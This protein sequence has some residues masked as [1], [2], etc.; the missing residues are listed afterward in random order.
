MWTSPLI[1][2]HALTPNNSY[3]ELHPF[4]SDACS[5]HSVARH[6]SV[7][8]YLHVHFYEQAALHMATQGAW[9]KPGCD[10]SS[11]LLHILCSLSPFVLTNPLR[12][13]TWKITVLAQSY[14]DQMRV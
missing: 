3:H 1:K 11:V 2:T 8:H 4:Y 7:L 6:T 14:G 5:T 9:T 10:S 12:G 13:L